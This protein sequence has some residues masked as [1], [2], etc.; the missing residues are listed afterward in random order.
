MRFVDTNVLIYAASR[1]TADPERRHRARAL[2]SEPNLAVSVQVLQEFYHQA[3]RPTRRDCLSHGQALKFL[4][5][6]LTLPVQAMTVEIFQ[7]AAIISHRFRLSYWDGA[8]LAAARLAGC[9]A[10]YSEDFSA[11]QDYGG[12]RIINP[13]T[14]AGAD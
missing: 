11:E 10:V 8:I 7:A 5:P 12:L 3:T 1:A 6:I 9:G 4:E 14:D 13:F 2:L